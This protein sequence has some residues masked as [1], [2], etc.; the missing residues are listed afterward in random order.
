MPKL[1]EMS[2]F[3]TQNLD[4]HQHHRHKLQ[5]SCEII[6]LILNNVFPHQ[7][8]QIKVRPQLYSKKCGNKN[9]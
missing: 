8:T 9:L 4:L 6:R 7:L 3:W 1:R 2:N 5:V